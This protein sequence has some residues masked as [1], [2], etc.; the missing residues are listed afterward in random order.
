MSEIRQVN[1]TEFNRKV[2]W[3]NNMCVSGCLV[4]SKAKTA[5]T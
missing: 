5:T 4:R 2:A 3:M 1:S